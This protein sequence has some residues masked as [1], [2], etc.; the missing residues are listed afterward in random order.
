MILNYENFTN[1]ETNL[2]LDMKLTKTGQ[3][4][5]T[6]E[7]TITNDKMAIGPMNSIL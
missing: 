1:C 5:E 6:I 4:N 2:Y 7:N 3:T